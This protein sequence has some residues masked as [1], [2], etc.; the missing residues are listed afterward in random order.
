MAKRYSDL[1]DALDELSLHLRAEGSGRASRDHQL[2]AS[3]IRT[4]EDMPPDPSEMSDVS[5]RT[6]DSIAEW[7]A[8][9][10]IDKLEELRE[11]RPYLSSLCQIA[12]VGPSTAENM[13]SEFGAETVEDVKQLDEDGKLEDVTGIGPKT[14]TTIRRS[15]AQL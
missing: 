10:E 14:A 8:Y 12:K 4:A 5:V 9:G 15:I 1:A 7:R 13:Y 2:A 6:R 3:H 11:K